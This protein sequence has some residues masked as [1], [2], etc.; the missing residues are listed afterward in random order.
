[1]RKYRLLGAIFVFVFIF[2]VPV[3]AREIPSSFNYSVDFFLSI[4]MQ[5]D[6][7]EELA[8][9]FRFFENGLG[10]SINGTHV[11]DEF[12]FSDFMQI[13]LYN[14]SDVLHTLPV[15]IP[16]MPLLTIMGVDLSEPIRIWTE[17]DFTNL[18]EP[19]IKFIFELPS[20]LRLMLTFVDEAFARQ[21]LVLDM[22]EIMTDLFSELDVEIR[23]IS[24]EQMSEFVHY[25][26]EAASDLQSDI[27]EWMT[28]AQSEMSD[29]LTIHTF[30]RG[31][32]RLEDAFR[33]Y[34]ELDFAI[35]D[36]DS[37]ANF[38][39]EFNAAFTNINNVTE[40]VPLPELTP[41]NS[42]SPLG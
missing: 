30:K 19:D 32:E 37:A 25:F 3:Q 33:V 24:D 27:M 29:Y 1:M 22:T 18:S 7:Y 28:Y 17:A 39:L 9:I 12:A 6:V 26:G 14:L 41:E 40:R 8:S 23:L 36:R 11:R 4:E 5:G 42:F 31:V 10:F 21:F 16:I 2:V 13:G 35:S 20:V 38:V 34:V 15:D